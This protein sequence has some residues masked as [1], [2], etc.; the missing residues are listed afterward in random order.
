M[1]S[2]MICECLT[3][4]NTVMTMFNVVLNNLVD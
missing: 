4:I 1:F 3:L 2:N